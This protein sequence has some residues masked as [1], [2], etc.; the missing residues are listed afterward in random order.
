MNIRLRVHEVEN[1]VAMGSCHVSIELE[2][3]SSPRDRLIAVS[4]K[5]LYDVEV[6]CMQGKQRAVPCCLARLGGGSRIGISGVTALKKYSVLT[7]AQ[8][9]READDWSHGFP[10]FPP[11]FQLPTELTPAARFPFARRH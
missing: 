4:C 1:S 9:G 5:E 3:E 10:P 11:R 7:A 8:R 2:S 6:W